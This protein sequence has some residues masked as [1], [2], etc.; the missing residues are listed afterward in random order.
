MVFLLQ[1]TLIYAAPLLI[2]ALGGMF[3]ERSGVINLAL[4][5]EMIFG[6]FCGAI[7]ARFFAMQGILMNNLQLM[8]LI[9]M[10]FSALCGALFGLLLSFSAINLK[11]DQTIGGTALNMLAAA[12]VNA[13]AL[14]LFNSEKIQMPANFGGYVMLNGDLPVILQVFGDKAYLS[15][16][17][18]VIVFIALSI[19][20]YKTKTGMRMRSCGEHPQAAASVGINVFKMRYLGTMISG[21]LAGLGGYAYIAT[22]ANGTAEASVGG[23]GFLA[24]AIMIFGNWKPLGIALGAILFGFLK[25][26]GP[27]SSSLEFLKNLGLPMYFYNII[28]YV[29]VLIVLALT[30]KKSGCPKAEGIPYDKGMR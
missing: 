29:V 9:V 19:W 18:I 23:M 30:A 27:V 15:T 6:A 10:L 5:G 24:L 26:I 3:S 25:C 12:L 1:K 20:I 16:Y 21:A 22:V 4:E 11:A 14:S 28:P 8:F 7:L 13:F 17:V 2:V